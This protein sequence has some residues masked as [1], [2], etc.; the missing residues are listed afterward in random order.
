VSELHDPFHDRER[1]SVVREPSQTR[2]VYAVID[3][4]N[5]NLRY[6]RHHSSVAAHKQADSLNEAYRAERRA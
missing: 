5:G 4:L 3:K 1:F 6:S 2:M